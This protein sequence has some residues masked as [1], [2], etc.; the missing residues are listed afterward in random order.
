MAS[1]TGV[2]SA[3]E[4][5]MGGLPE[6]MERRRLMRGSMEEGSIVL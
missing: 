5:G 4:V 6:A 1:V 3:E 2:G